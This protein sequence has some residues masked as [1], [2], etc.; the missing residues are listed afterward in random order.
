MQTNFTP[1][2]NAS[3]IA[4]APDMYHALVAIIW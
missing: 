3:L 2:P 4:A 1:G